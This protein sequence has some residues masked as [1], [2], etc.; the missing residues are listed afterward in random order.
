MRNELIF[1][2]DFEIR[3]L[4]FIV[5]IGGLGVSFLKFLNLHLYAEKSLSRIELFIGYYFDVVVRFE[6]L[7]FTR[8]G[9]S[10]LLKSYF[11][12]I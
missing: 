10:F 5:G 11:L 9:L 6:L 7:I 2:I 1:S 4:R 3:F 8:S 12:I